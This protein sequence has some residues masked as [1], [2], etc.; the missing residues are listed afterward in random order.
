MSLDSKRSQITLSFGESSGVRSVAPLMTRAIE[1]TDGTGA[2]KGQKTGIATVTPGGSTVTIALTSSSDFTDADGNSIT[3][4][5][6]KAIGYQ[7]ASGNSGNITIG[8]NVNEW[9]T[10]LKS[11]GATDKGLIVLAPDTTLGLVTGSANGY[12]VTAGDVIEVNGTGTDS[13]V[14]VVMGEAS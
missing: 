12:A 3:F 6:I 11:S 13:V 10:F 9:D 5:K 1:F 8:G 4:T 14:I 2:L 7:A